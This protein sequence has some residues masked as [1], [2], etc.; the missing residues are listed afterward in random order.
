[1]RSARFPQKATGFVYL[2]VFLFAIWLCLTRS[3]HWQEVLT[4]AAVSLVLAL[5]LSESYSTLGLPRLN[6]KRLM[7]FVAYLGVL[8]KEVVQAN[9][10]VAYRILHPRMPL[11]PGIVAVRTG[12]KQD[13]AKLML[14]NSITLTPGTFT[15][16]IVGD[17]LLVHW[18]DVKGE[19]VE[20]STRIIGE[21][22]EKYLRLIFE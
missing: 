19:T 4:G 22:F 1:M 20:E 17:T 10:D 16:D 2:L 6:P 8:L 3:A 12:L 14:A 13:I 21:K 15:M 18:I 9:F 7:G 11:R 5:F